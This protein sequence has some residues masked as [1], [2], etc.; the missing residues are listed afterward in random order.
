MRNVSFFPIRFI[1]F[2][3]RRPAIPQ[4]MVLANQGV[5]NVRDNTNLLSAIG[6][7]LSAISFEPKARMR[8]SPS[9]V[10]KELAAHSDFDPITFRILN[11]V[12]L[13][14]KIDCAP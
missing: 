8:A 6:Y 1:D 5:P 14:S 7:R 10:R 13:H 4:A 2:C 12:N 9:L 11:F 3:V